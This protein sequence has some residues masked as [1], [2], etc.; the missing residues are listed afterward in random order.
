MDSRLTALAA[1]KTPARHLAPQRQAIGPPDH[2]EAAPE[3][4]TGAVVRAALLTRAAGAIGLGP[5]A[6]QSPTVIESK[7]TFT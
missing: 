7:V 2:A 1:I 3:A 4:P 5:V 6:G